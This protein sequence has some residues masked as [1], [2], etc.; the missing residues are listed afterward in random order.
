M[1]KKD[2]KNLGLGDITA[3]IRGFFLDSQIEEAAHISL[4]MGCASISDDV[5][6]REVEESDKRVARISHL[7]PLLYAYAHSMADGIVE[8]QRFHFEEAQADGEEIELP[9]EAWT[10]TRTVFMQI[11]MN[12]LMG[13]L[14][15]L[16][17]MEV[18]TVKKKGKFSWLKNMTR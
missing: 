13:G 17:D 2:I 4:L 12:T 3:R 11:A 10:S 7:V 6:E 8:H 5:A 1:R 9:S 16:V 14:S 15:Q 18:V